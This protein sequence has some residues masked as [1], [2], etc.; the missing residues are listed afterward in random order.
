LGRAATYAAWRAEPRDACEPFDVARA[1]AARRLATRLVDSAD[2]TGGWLEAGSTT[3]L[4]APYGLTPSGR[5]AAGP[6]EAARAA[7]EL[8]YPVAVKSASGDVVHKTERGLVRVGIADEVE[9]RDTL[10]AFAAELGRVDAPV[11][12]QPMATGVEMALGVV[13]DPAF[14]PLVMLGAGGVVTDL[15]DDRVFLVPPVTRRD[16]ARALRSLRTWPLLAGHRGGQAA[17]V[18]AL[19]DVAVRLGR[20][21]D[22]VPEVAELDLNPVIVT[23][24][25]AVLVDVKV[26]LDA[27]GSVDAGV[28][29]RL[30]RP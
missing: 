19:E 25:G 17:D 16:V 7:A 12:V 6:D 15:W 20:L 28:P 24:A 9:L 14:G 8:G 22:E 2:G 29:R 5:T 4:L 21:V 23:A 26:R 11:L 18:D 1:A 27:A 13:R 10:G 3:A 30:R